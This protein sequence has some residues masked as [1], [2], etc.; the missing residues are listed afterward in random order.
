MYCPDLPS[1]HLKWL[2]PQK[3]LICTTFCVVVFLTL[4]S[5]CCHNLRV[6]E[7]SFLDRDAQLH[8]ILSSSHTRWGSPWGC[9]DTQETP[10]GGPPVSHP[11]RLGMHWNTQ[12]CPC[13]EFYIGL[14][15]FIWKSKTHALKLQLLSFGLCSVCNDGIMCLGFVWSER[16]LLPAHRHAFTQRKRGAF[17]HQRLG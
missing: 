9:T 16:S 3:P 8:F 14:I 6:E 12:C 13:I 15:N 1:L 2:C 17:H 10:P 11:M 7:S 5:S 4:I